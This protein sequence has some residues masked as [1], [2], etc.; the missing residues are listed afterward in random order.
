MPPSDT[1][2][3]AAV[4]KILER[5][6]AVIQGG[7]WGGYHADQTVADL[8]RWGLARDAALRDAQEEARELSREPSLLG[9]MLY[10]I[11]E[12]VEA[13][14][15]S[16]KESAVILHDLLT[17]TTRILKGGASVG[18][19]G[20]VKARLDEAAGALAALRDAEAERDKAR[21]ACWEAMRYLV[22]DCTVAGQRVMRILA[23]ARGEAWAPG[24]TTK[25]TP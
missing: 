16:E 3:E 24:P 12:V 15:N 25:E 13:A 21:S 6:E 11:G 9:A 5:V 18:V 4:R 23:E 22:T 2:S 17:A 14:G 8:C 1:L 7:F 19:V 10:A 20:Q